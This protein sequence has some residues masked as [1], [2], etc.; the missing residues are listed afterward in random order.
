MEQLGR[1]PLN[2]GIEGRNLWITPKVT[3]PLVDRG[4]QYFDGVG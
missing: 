2:T 1:L 3:G 4:R